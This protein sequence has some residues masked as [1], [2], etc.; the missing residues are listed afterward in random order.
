MCGIAGLFDAALKAGDAA[1]VVAA[2]TSTLEHRGPDDDG[3]Y[4]AD[5]V[6][7]GMRRLSIIDLA[8]GQQPVATEDGQIHAVFNGEIYNFQHLRAELA[9]RGH[10]FRSRSDSEVIAHAYEEHGPSFVKDLAGMFAIALWDARE[11]R[12][13]LARDRVGKKPLYYSINPRGLLFGSEPKALLAADASLAEPD[14]DATAWYLRYGFVPEPRTAFRR[15]SVLPAAHYLLYANGRAITRPYWELPLEA[16][17]PSDA[18]TDDVVEQLD[19]SLLEAVRSRLISDVPL[20]V[21]LSGGID[22]STVAAYA[23]RA[24]EQQLKTFTIGFDRPEWD[25]SPDADV[26]ARHLGTEHHVLTL[27]EDDLTRDLPETLFTL[28]RHFDQ[29]FGDPSALPTYHVSRLARE[30]VKVILGGDGADELFAGYSTYLGVRFAEYYRQLPS[31]LAAGI[32]PWMAE[33]GARVVGDRQRYRLLRAAKVFRDSLFPFPE[34][35]FR[36][37]MV[38]RDDSLRELFVSSTDDGERA[39]PPYL[40][41]LASIARAPVSE[42][43]KAGHLDVRFILTNRM[44][45]KIDRMSMANSLEIRSPF[46][47]HRLVEFV[48]KLPPSLKLRGWRSK[49]ILR[50]TVRPHLPPSVL[51]KPKQGFNVPLR[52]WLRNGLY[53]LASD[54]LASPTPALPT[55]VFDITRVRALLAEHRAGKWDHSDAIWILLNY[56]AWH[57]EYVVKKRFPTAGSRSAELRQAGATA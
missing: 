39:L 1:R 6:A 44:L 24:T 34:L 55:D 11:R 21:F 15:I 41:E 54:F 17:S 9:A 10:S 19:E 52:A 46:L 37:K 36:K 43:T 56:A 13:L 3:F 42:V 47:D 31:F 32:L 40:D 35:Y 26:V 38:L 28:V 23:A 57:D 7:L 50:D 29:P 16:E 18:R 12:L 49:A 5:N 51:R 8:G 53:E 33:H 45:P 22:S 27:R 25:E 14:P 30:H 48:A 20:G 2:M 4:A